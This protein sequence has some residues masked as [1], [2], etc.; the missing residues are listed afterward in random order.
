M[1]AAEEKTW[2]KGQPGHGL[3]G[4]GVPGVVVKAPG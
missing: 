2:E 3:A 4:M 1:K